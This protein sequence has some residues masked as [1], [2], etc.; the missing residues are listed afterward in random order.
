VPPELSS[1][2]PDPAPCAHASVAWSDFA[3]RLAQVLARLGDREFLIVEIART[4]AYVQ[5]AASA[6]HGLRAETVSNLYLSGASMLDDAQCAALARADWEA[7]RPGE[8]PNYFRNFPMPGG[9]ATAAALAIHTL[10]DIHGVPD[11][12]GLEYKAFASGSGFLAFPSLGLQRSVPLRE[13]LL[14]C[15]RLTCGTPDLDYDKDGGLTLRYGALRVFLGIVR[16]DRYV[17]LCTAVAR[18]LADS[19]EALSFVNELNRRIPRIQ[20]WFDVGAIRA[21]LDLAAEPFVARHLSEGIAEFC[22]TTQAIAR[23]LASERGESIPVVT[24]RP[25][26]V[27]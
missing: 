11:P 16:K 23:D 2:V 5:F 26:T 3:D 15:A 1:T 4:H 10:R 8:S 12:S 18:G 17:R 24:E 7:P 21:D 19:A 22:G 9:A 14:D 25:P 6:K 20:F 13:A 27:H